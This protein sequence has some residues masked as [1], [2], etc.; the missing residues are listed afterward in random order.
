MLQIESCS[1]LRMSFYGAV[2]IAAVA[3]LRIFF[4][5]RLPKRTFL[6]LWGIALCRLLVPVSIASEYSVYS[7]ARE[8]DFAAAFDRMNAGETTGLPEEALQKEGGAI[9]ESAQEQDAILHTLPAGAESFFA[10]AHTGRISVWFL[11]WCAGAAACGIFFTFWYVRCRLE[12]ATSL[13]VA[14]PLVDEWL[15]AHRLRRL[16]TVRQSDRIGAPLTY[17]ILKPVIL[18][19]KKTD[20]AD[21]EGLYYVLLHEYVHIRHFD[22]VTKLVMVCCCVLH[23]FNP[24]VWVMYLLLGR[25]M[26]L[27]CDE[28]VLRRMGESNKAVYARLL[29]SMEEKKS[30]MLPF[31]NSF[32]K[33]VMK[34]RIRAIMKIKRRALWGTLAAAIVMVIVVVFFATSRAAKAPYSE[35]PE[36]FRPILEQWEA[37]QKQGPVLCLGADNGLQMNYGVAKPE[38]VETGYDSGQ[39]G[40]APENGYVYKIDWL[41]PKEGML[42]KDVTIDLSAYSLAERSFQGGPVYWYQD[43]CFYDGERNVVILTFDISPMDSYDDY[44]GPLWLIA[45]F[46]PETP[47]EYQITEVRDVNDTLWFTSAF[48]I[49]DFIFDGGGTLEPKLPASI[50]CL[51][52][53]S[54]NGSVAEKAIQEALADFLEDYSQTEPESPVILFRVAA[55]DGDVIVYVGSVQKDEG[56]EVQRSV[57]AAV[58]KDKL[59]HVM[60]IDETT[61]EI[62]VQ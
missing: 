58:C 20:W 16:V 54:S 61:G 1:L 43:G 28:S 44:E 52:K 27:L 30:G 36:Y 29:I 49:G 19:P 35:Y 48:R 25:D 18:L 3:V 46:R 11:L 42:L 37:A 41:K 21:K 62:T 13:P 15:S 34:E 53:E 57:Y 32:S 8:G 7:F 45:E 23:W 33:N 10:G 26:E 38:D 17:G 6:V 31:C 5:N 60:I 55:V 22:T 2:L 4:V 59:L 56:G 39:G 51:T 14:E 40:G 50:H 24:L 47:Q 12:F 9:G